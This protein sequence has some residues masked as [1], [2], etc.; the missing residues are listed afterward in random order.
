MK[1]L[2]KLLRCHCHCCEKNRNGG[3]YQPLG[4]A[5]PPHIAPSTPVPEFTPPRPPRKL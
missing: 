4:R 3:G 2:E 5:N 1:W